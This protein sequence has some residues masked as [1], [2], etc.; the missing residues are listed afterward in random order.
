MA[1]SDLHRK[2]LQRIC[3][4]CSNINPPNKLRSISDNI[5]DNYYQHWGEDLRL[6]NPNFM[7]SVICNTCRIYLELLKTG[8]TVSEKCISL[9]P[10]SFDEQPNLRGRVP[11]SAETPC[12]LCQKME[13]FSN[14]SIL[15]RQKKSR[16]RSVGR[17]PLHSVEPTLDVNCGTCFKP[18]SIT[19]RESPARHKC[20]S[21]KNKVVHHAMNAI[22]RSNIAESD[23]LSATVP[24]SM[25]DDENQPTSSGVLVSLPNVTGIGGPPKKVLITSPGSFTGN[26]ISPFAK[27]DWFEEHFIY[28]IK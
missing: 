22:N 15:N 1:S 14:E 17:K 7:P 2:A 19:E 16:A 9:S 13:I 8:K 27:F 4:R 21:V 18:L 26:T 20:A 5:R 12:I 6:D 10:A 25:H 3:R 24:V 11:C 28:H 23:V